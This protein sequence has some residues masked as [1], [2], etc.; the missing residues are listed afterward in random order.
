[1]FVTSPSVRAVAWLMT[2]VTIGG[3]AIFILIAGLD[4]AHFESLTRKDAEGDTGLVE[5]LT[6]LCLI[7]AI[8][9]SIYALVRWQDRLPSRLL[10][11][12]LTLWIAA[13]VYFAGEEASWGQWYFGYE[14][15]EV[16]AQLN[17]QD[18][19]NLHNM[20]SWLD[21]KPRAMVKTFIIVAGLLVPVW[22]WFR[23]DNQPPLVARYASLVYWVIAPPMCWVAAAIVLGQRIGSWI[24]LPLMQ[25]V[26]TSE[27]RELGIA[28]FLSLYLLSFVVRMRAPTADLYGR[29][30]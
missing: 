21:Q 1:M 11:V 22:L 23:R 12:W 29:S 15:P 16:I 2:G 25:R 30:G 3:A 18:E 5:H 26:G 10:V 6:V 9:A 8:L 24:D 19:F 14:T 13:C 4:P 17:D 7:P 20:S 27:F 28:W